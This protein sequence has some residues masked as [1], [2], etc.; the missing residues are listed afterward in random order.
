METD[1]KTTKLAAASCWF[2]LALLIIAFIFLF[3]SISCVPA[4]HVG[5]LSVFGNVDTDKHLVEGFN[6]KNPLASVAKMSIRTQEMSMTGADGITALANDGLNITVDV[7]VRF[8]L[9]P[10]HAPEMFQGV[11]MRWVNIILG[12]SLRTAVRDAA[13]LYTSQAIYADDR[14]A[15]C[16]MVSLNLD[17]ELGNYAIIIDRVQIRSIQLP[18]AIREAIDEKLEAEQE[19]ERMEHVLSI[20]SKT[21]EQRRIEAQGIADANEIINRTLTPEY[22]QWYYINTMSNLAGSNNTTWVLMP[23]DSGLVPM[24]NL[25]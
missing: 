10:D 25:K 7:T 16:E 20:E 2:I 24:M 5:V 22:L 3:R 12:P 23:F 21:A 15:F 9:N 19:M 4:G 17:E 14:E 13:S 8:R 11:G 6:I 18:S 1:Q